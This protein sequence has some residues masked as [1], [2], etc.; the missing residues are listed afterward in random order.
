[1]TLSG[2]KKNYSRLAHCSAFGALKRET[3]GQ[4]RITGTVTQR[5]RRIKKVRSTTYSFTPKPGRPFLTSQ[6]Q[7]RLEQPYQVSLENTKLQASSCCK[8]RLRSA[9]ETRGWGAKTAKHQGA[10]RPPRP[11]RKGRYHQPGSS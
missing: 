2:G 11:V 7:E 1:M 4:P 3:C 5:T 10:G 9:G 8:E 6:T